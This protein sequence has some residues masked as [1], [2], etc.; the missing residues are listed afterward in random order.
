MR[1]KTQATR[2]IVIIMGAESRRA[3]RVL[4]STAMLVCAAAP[5]R[6]EPDL[7]ATSTP[8]PSVSAA[9]VGLPGPLPAELVAAPPPAS[10][11]LELPP[12][13][14]VPEPA[15]TLA[16]PGKATVNVATMRQAIELY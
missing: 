10:A 13:P 11:G 12:V 5:V 6:A 7:P 1:A 15:I 2:G 16:E 14:E 3:L 4:A 9:E 8:L